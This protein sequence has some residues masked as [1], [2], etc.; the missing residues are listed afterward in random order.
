MNR[1]LPG[2]WKAAAAVALTAAL[3]TPLLVF[4]GT[5]FART[6]SA[7]SEYE[8]SSASQYQYRMVICHVT[9]SRKHPAHTITISSRAWHAH[10]RHGDHLGP[11][12]GTET[13]PA[14][15]HG[16]SGEHHGESG[17][18]HGQSGHGTP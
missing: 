15:Q 10:R 4:G 14:K 18:H 11:C 13:A 5:A 1:H 7:A 12:T 2:S 17:E 3:F 8:Y 6:G 9:H 16:K